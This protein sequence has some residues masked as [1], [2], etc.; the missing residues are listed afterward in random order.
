VN[1]ESILEGLNSEQREAVRTTEGPL[2]VLAGAGSG[3]TRVLVHRIA[4]LVGACGIPA[5]SILA[6]T[7]T[8]KAAGEMRERVQ[9]LLGP[10]A[11][12]I[13]V[14]TFH[15]TC[16]RILRRDIGHLGRSRGFSIY[17]DAD[18]L[19]LIKQAI[20]R[21][22]LDPKGV[23][24]RGIRWRID[25][26][27]NAGVL[28][29]QAA[30]AAS[31][32]DTETAAELYATYQRLLADANALDFGDLLLETV[33]LFQRH[34]AVLEYYRRRWQYVLVDEYQDTNRVQY[35]LVNQLAGQ[36]RNLCVVGDP[37]QSIYAWR[38]A[39]VRNILDFGRDFS[40][41]RVVKLERNYRSTEPILAGA[42][43]VVANNVARHPKR[44][45]TDR[46]GGDPIRLYEAV[47]DR[48]EARF[49][50]REILART[51]E[52]GRARGDC[53]IFYRTNSQSRLFEEELLRA[54]V[55]YAVV[56]GV[57]FYERAEIKDVLAYLRLLVNPGDELA[58]RRVVN[59]PPRGIG[60][61]TLERAEALSAQRGVSLREAF[62][63]AASSGELRRAGSKVTAFLALL[64]ELEREVHGLAPS[65]AIAKVLHRSGL[66]E[67]LE[68]DPAPEAQGRLENLRELCVGA[69]D[70]DA[71]GAAELG[72]DRSA[73]ERF[74]DRVALVSAVDQYDRRT[75]RVS[76][77]TAHTAKG[78]EYPFVFLVG[79][80]EGLFPHAA[81]A[82]DDAGVEEERRL[83]YVGMTRAM[84]RLTISFAR[85][86]R[87]FGS[88]S[89]A[90]PS[91]FL[92]EIPRQ[93]AEGRIGSGR[94]AGADSGSGRRVDYAYSQVEA[95]DATATVQGLRVRHPIFG[96]GTVIEVS[97]ARGDEKLKIRFDRVGVKTVM[98]RFANLEQI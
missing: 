70:F 59:T 85:E 2:L 8:N 72:E 49:V 68:R 11:G 52:G 63:L 78:L 87:R 88:R 94:A 57:R 54:D 97:G 55:P 66:V 82:H 7:F 1:T 35:D 44:L 27:K 76:L 51:R 91:R 20:Q 84:E 37:D 95:S 73:L 89:V 25:R 83:C 96:A 69:E 17:D 5:D 48:D 31:D 23:P 53:A 65:E 71:E 42:S 86:R 90:V 29:A 12:E 41:A 74:L 62:G 16:V 92:E 14:S 36:H 24:P 43:A 47:D 67:Q 13:W 50:V 56:G 34:P 21:H 64:D 19:G 58:L 32:L 26:W 93:H 33:A 39:D 10:E 15:S 45:W 81:S 18:S 28:P 3:K 75:D 77:M 6:V 4:Y 9:K 30:N 80:E 38:G 98:V 22:S 61:T 60:R 40:D 46:A 79:M